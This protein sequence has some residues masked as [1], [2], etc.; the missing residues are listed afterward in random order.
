MNYKY[1]MYDPYHIKQCTSCNRPI[2]THSP[3]L[4]KVNS[5][6]IIFFIKDWIKIQLFI[7]LFKKEEPLYYKVYRV[8]N[9][10]STFTVRLLFIENYILTEIVHFW[11]KYMSD[12]IQLGTCR[13]F[14]LYQISKH[15]IQVELLFL[16]FYFNTLPA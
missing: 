9:H 14:S 7:N 1:A 10:T 16:F 3:E 6:I 15:T 2:D 13:N 5:I 8:I 11:L 12:S 4:N